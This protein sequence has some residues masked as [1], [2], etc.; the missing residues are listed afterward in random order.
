VNSGYI[1]GGTVP[2]AAY[3]LGIPAV[4]TLHDYWY[5]CPTVSLLR[6]DGRLCDQ[7]V[8]PAHCAWCW[9]TQR[10]R[11][12]LPDQYLH[13]RVGDCFASLGRW[14]V[15]QRLLGIEPLLARMEERRALMY[16]TLHRMDRVISPSRFLI[17][18]MREY[19]FDGDRIVYL[20]FGL[21]RNGST[22]QATERPS[23]PRLRIGYLG[24]LAPHKGVHVLMDA[25]RH[26]PGPLEGRELALH[27]QMFSGDSYLKRL[28]SMA[29]G[30]SNVKFAG[31]YPNAAVGQVLRD[32]DVVVV[33]SVWYENRPTVIIEAFASGTPV[34][35]ARL[36]GM[37]ELVSHGENGLLFES[38]S[39]DSLREQLQR[40]L[41]EPDL[42]SHLRQ[43]ISPVPT[44]DDEM[45]ALV[46]L[47]KEIL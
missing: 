14:P 9:L 23:L 11:Y 19:G 25:F 43:G 47:Y 5:L 13:G 8:P 3:R 45:A 46:S 33:P 17:A 18:K 12:R 34:I 22:T 42:L 37:A 1:L 29:N 15:A 44:P 40:L 39:A 41:D 35:A 21:E 6:S 4:L 24:Q 36:G 27:G 10:R 28:Q 32:L 30:D 26:L 7:P 38:G 31:P 20:P 16:D 2:E